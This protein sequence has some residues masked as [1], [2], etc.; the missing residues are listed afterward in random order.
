MKK[1]STAWK[2]DS[3]FPDLIENMKGLQLCPQKM[4]DKTGK[5]DFAFLCRLIGKA[6]PVDFLNAYFLSQQ[7]RFDST[8]RYGDGIETVLMAC[9]ALYAAL[10]R[11][12]SIQFLMTDR[13]V[14]EH[15]A[16]KNRFISGKLQKAYFKKANQF[17]R[18]NTGVDHMEEIFQKLKQGHILLAFLG[19]FISQFEKIG[20]DQCL[21]QVLSN[22]GMVVDDIAVFDED[23]GIAFSF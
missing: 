5:D 1:E 8:D 13:L 2:S 6:N 19:E 21:V 22:A 4:M 7:E 15:T 11:D 23:E 14:A 17:L 12:K 16:I 20:G 10:A 18:M 9:F 3:H